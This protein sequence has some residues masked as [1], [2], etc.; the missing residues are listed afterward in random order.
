[1]LTKE[2]LN[3]LQYRFKIDG[4]ADQTVEGVLKSMKD[5][6]KGQRSMILA[7]YNLFTRRQ[8]HC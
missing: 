5:Y 6:L 7:R 3:D 1:M 4:N 8:Q 2:L